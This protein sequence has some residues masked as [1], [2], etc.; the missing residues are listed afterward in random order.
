[1]KGPDDSLKRWTHPWRQF[2]QLS[3][4]K[5]KS[6]KALQ[7]MEIIETM[8]LSVPSHL[9]HCM[10]HRP[11]NTRVFAASSS[12]SSRLSPIPASEDFTPW[13]C[14]SPQDFGPCQACS[15]AADF[16]QRQHCQLDQL[17]DQ[18]SEASS[19]SSDVDQGT[20]WRWE[21]HHDLK[22]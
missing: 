22:P 1:M 12:S 2:L 6:T 17:S 18:D 16:F 20:P 14:R 3:K 19:L 13:R 9:P 4:D 11:G 7:I 10:D 5:K 21:D 8:D 15:D